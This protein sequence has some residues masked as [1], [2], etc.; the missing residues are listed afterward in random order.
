MESAQSVLVNKAQNCAYF[1][2][3]KFLKKLNLPSDLLSHLKEIPVKVYNGRTDENSNDLLS[4]MMHKNDLMY[5]IGAHEIFINQDFLDKLHAYYLEAGSEDKERVV[6]AFAREIVHELLHANSQCLLVSTEKD[7]KGEC[8]SKTDLVSAMGF[9]GEEYK[10]YGIEEGINN[11]LSRIIVNSHDSTNLDLPS[12]IEKI[13]SNLDPQKS[14]GKLNIYAADLINKRGLDFVEWYL[15]SAYQDVYTNP[16]RQ[17]LG[18]KKFI[19]QMRH[20]D[21]L[22]DKEM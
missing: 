10:G 6:K 11:I 5:V 8:K 13:K 9:T 17:E 19:Q 12:E 2:L 7:E 1:S 14:E 15:T 18:D 16:L 20:A 22:Y 4:I 3:E 21:K